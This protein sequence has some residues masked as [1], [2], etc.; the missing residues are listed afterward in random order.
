MGGA[1][2]IH[3]DDSMTADVDLHAQAIRSQG[4][5]VIEDFL[6]PGM[7]AE[8][9]SNLAPYLGSHTGR[10]RFEGSA[11]ERVYTLVARARVFWGIVLDPR[12][13]A[14]CERFLLP[15]FLLTA[16]QAIR[17]GP[18]EAAQALHY[19]DS[20]HH[21]PRPRA[22]ISLSTIVAV[23]AF[24]ADNGATRLLPGSHTWSDAQLAGLG[25]VADFSG[26]GNTG[27][28]ERQCIPAMLPAGAC[29]VFSGT[30]VHGGGANRSAAARLAFS[31]QYC[32]PWARPQENFILGVPIDVARA[33]P[34]RLQELLGYSIHPPFIGQLTAAH[35]AKALAPGYENRVVAQARAAGVRLPEFEVCH[36][37]RGLTSEPKPPG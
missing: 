18:G 13:L 26:R 27:A 7:L 5:T 9:R 28:L 23:D 35:P 19:D 25:D 21:L 11:T 16:S 17:I 30:L 37:A 36:S 34:A 2:P 20:F 14:L 6:T 12:I 8:V 4:Y 22:M 32:Q 3:R 10:N 33:M 15:N 1:T 31:N 29:L 24:T